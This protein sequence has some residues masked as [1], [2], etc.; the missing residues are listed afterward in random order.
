MTSDDL[1]LDREPVALL[2]G[3]GRP[4]PVAAAPPERH[5]VPAEHGELERRLE[6][7]LMVADE[8]QPLVALASALER[9]VADI[10]RAVQR[11]AADYDGADG[12]VRRGFELRE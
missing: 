10:R 3:L 11:L 8:P 1:A 7:I 12:G 6:A 2:L 9:P 4:A 5:S